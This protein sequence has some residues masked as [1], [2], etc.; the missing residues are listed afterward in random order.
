MRKRN[1]Q[2]CCLL[3]IGVMGGCTMFL[4]IFR[5]NPSVERGEEVRETAPALSL[6]DTFPY[7]DVGRGAVGEW[8]EYRITSAES[9]ES[10]RIALV[11]VNPALVEIEQKRGTTVTRWLQELGPDGKIARSLVV[12]GK[13][14][15]TEQDLLHPPT[16][17]KGAW[18]KVEEL[19]R[20]AE[21]VT[22]EKRTYPATRVESMMT[23]EEGRVSLETD[24]WCAE[25]PP[26]Y[27]DSPAGGLVKR[28]VDG[29]PAILLTGAGK[30]AVKSLAFP[31]TISQ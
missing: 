11:G 21:P 22:I 30:D 12:E 3:F 15:P 1:F 28:T 13:R 16:Q 26:F 14:A 31:A 17:P 10:L 4:D 5:T 6:D 24:W 2:L 19:A 7:G 8:V 9:A 27:A 25:V 29:H 20:S 18:P 23:S